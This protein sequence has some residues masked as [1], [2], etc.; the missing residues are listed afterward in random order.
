MSIEVHRPDVREFGELFHQNAHALV[1]LDAAGAIVMASMGLQSLLSRTQAELV[2]RNYLDFLR[3]EDRAAASASLAALA[4]RRD[5]QADAAAQRWTLL[6]A[7]AH[8]V[9]IDH[10]FSHTVSAGPALLLGVLQRVLDDDPSYRKLLESEARFRGLLAL[11]SDWYWEQDAQF[12]FTMFAGQRHDGLPRGA[13]SLLGLRRWD[14][15][16]EPIGMSWA[17][18]IAQLEAHQPFRNLILHRT[19][20]FSEHPIVI[21]VHGDP[22]FDADGNFV[23]YRGIASDI[24]KEQKAQLAIAEAE[25]RY[26]ALVNVAADGIIVLDNGVIEFVNDTFVQMMRAGGPEEFLG[27]SV[28]DFVHPEYLESVH[29][30][31]VG[32]MRGETHI[33]PF[34]ERKL[35]RKDG[36]ILVVE[37]RGATFAS[38]GR[39]LIQSVVRDVSRYRQ[40]EDDLRRSEERFRDMAEAAGEYVWEVDAEGHYTYLSDR[41]VDV[42]GYTKEEL[43]GEKPTAFVPPEEHEAMAAWF[44]A[45]ASQRDFR[46]LEHRSVTKSG[47]VIWQQVSAV[48]VRDGG[49]AVVG[50]RGTG[51]D[52]TQQKLSE[53]QARRLATHDALTGLPNRALLQDRLQHSLAKAERAATQLGVLFIDLDKFKRI[54]DL[55][56][57]A[58]GDELLRQAARRLTEVLRGQDTLCRIG[59]DEFVAV[60]EPVESR[61]ELERTGARII[62][63]LT[64]EFHLLSGR[65]SVGASVGISVFP[66][67]AKTPEDLI[68]RADAAM[69]QAKQR[70]GGQCAVYSAELGPGTDERFRFEIELRRAIMQNEFRVHLQPIFDA[71]DGALTGAEALIRWQHPE[72]GLLPPGRFVPAAE[73]ANLISALGDWLINEVARHLHQWHQATGKRI[74]VA[75]N[76][77]VQQL[78]TGLDFVDYLEEVVQ[79]H[80]IPPECLVLEVTESLLV[81]SLDAVASTLRAARDLGMK[82]SMDDFGTGYS[83]LHLLRHLPID[84]IKVDRAFVRNLKRDEKDFAVLA[85]VIQLARALELKVV[86]E[87]VE[88]QHHVELLRELG[89]DQ[90]QGFLFARPMP[91]EEFSA[92]YV[93]QPSHV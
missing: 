40:I 4:Q 7:D 83:S 49:G 90:V 17:E 75:V 3:P 59:G 56:G 87:G 85:A 86:A 41:V 64:E 79:R 50:Y 47:E 30:R 18:H 38:G 39:M 12:R 55:L 29:A 42:L 27:R 74:K 26:R 37:M 19:G 24:T 9:R 6:G 65:F 76:V 67:D 8:P 68:R 44:A 60:I 89:F 2:G 70:G 71:R 82:V 61:A 43:L 20:V 31:S 33:D 69:Y 15:P 35:V 23:G 34:M 28:A 78:A 36:T 21:S 73:A 10:C 62:K 45:H 51:L 92:R 80:Q 22:V 48:A 77:S 54:N 13:Y 1:V 93:L 25:E 53:Q 14:T 63:A 46:N 11:S 66:E 32:L 58:S 88:E 91:V 84:T 57:H 72:R 16:G 52:V 81:Q 5:V